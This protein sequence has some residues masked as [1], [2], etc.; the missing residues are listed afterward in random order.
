M[1]DAPAIERMG[2]YL[3]VADVEQASEFYSALF[4]REPEYS[5]PVFVSFD[6]AGGQF[7]LAARSVFAPQ[8]EIGDNGVPN[9]R[10]ADIDAM[11][12][13][14]RRVAPESVVSPSVNREGPIA[15]FKLRDPDGNLVEFY[16]L[17]SVSSSSSSD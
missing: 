7:A 14:V 9:I 6:I 5:S 2:S 16:S 17:P 12:D 13:H 4:G 15:L 8:A 1:V 11:F 3:V 10:V